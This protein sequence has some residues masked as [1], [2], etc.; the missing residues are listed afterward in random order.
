[1][2]RSWGDWNEAD[3]VRIL[4]QQGYRITDESRP[5]A[6]VDTPEKTFLSNVRRLAIVAR[7]IGASQALVSC[8]SP[9]A[10]QRRADGAG[11][12][13]GAARRRASDSG[14]LERAGRTLRQCQP[15][16]ADHGRARHAAGAVGLYC[17]FH[18]GSGA[19][20]FGRRR[21]SERGF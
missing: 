5:A 13:G 18:R 15:D 1:M 16:H 7:L 6:V 8:S 10:E 11:L 4:Q 12:D 2:S 20:L 14:H 21:L 9:A 3:L 19:R 17:G